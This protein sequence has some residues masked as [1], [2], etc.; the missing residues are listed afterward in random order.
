MRKTIR[1]K[2]P[3]RPSTKLA[4]LRG[5]ELTTT[6]KRRSIETSKLAK[7]LR[8]DLDWIVMKCLEKDR[9]RR[10]E[11]A[12]GLAMD[13]KRHL[14]N[15][16]VVARPPSA[17]Y[18]LQKSFR[19]NKLVFAAGAAVFVALL[20][21]MIA[22]VW[23][24]A[25]A[26][27]A[28]HEAVSARLDAEAR[29][30]EA[31][32]A[33]KA[34]T[35]QRVLA[36][37]NAAQARENE[38]HSRKLL[39]AADMN[40][41]QQSLQLNNVGR[42]RQL[43]DRHRPAPGEED[44]RGWEWRYLWQQC[45]SDALATLAKRPARGFSVSFSPDGTLL[46][47]GYLDGKIELWD[48]ARRVLLKVIETNGPGAH[49]AFSPRANL[50]AATGNGN[51]IKLHDLADGDDA[52]MWQASYES[53]RELSFS[54][55]GTRLLAFAHTVNG[56]SAVM[57]DAA[58]GQS[59]NTNATKG[60]TGHLGSARLSSDQRRLYLSHA[61]NKTRQITVKCLN[62]ETGQE[63]W[64]TKVGVD[65]GVSAMA[66]SPDDKVL[67]T[68]TGY[69]DPTIR[70][71]DAQTGKLLNKLEG[72]TG[73]VGELAF[74]RDG[75]WLASAAADQSIRLWNT[76]DWT[77]ARVFRG[78][79]NEVHAVA[80]SPDGR[81]LASG[82]KDGAIMLWDVAA[83]QSATE[84]RRLPGEA[85][86]AVEVSPGNAAT[87]N[88]E[89][90]L[91]VNLLR[92]DDISQSSIQLPA[93][94]EDG[95]RL[96][97]L[98]PNLLGVY[99][100]T[101][102]LRICEVRDQTFKTL[103]EFVVG[104]NLAVRPNIEREFGLGGV[105]LAYCQRQRLVAWGDSS[106]TVQIVNVDQPAQRIKIN[107]DL[108]DP[109]AIAFSP[110]GKLV[111]LTGG[112][113]GQGLELRDAKTGKLLLHSDLQVK[114]PHAFFVDDGRG[115]VAICAR[116][117]N[118]Q[119]DL[120]ASHQVMFWDLAHPENPPAQFPEHG[121]L[122]GLAASPDGRWVSVCSQEGFI[123]I[124]DAHTR[125][126]NKVL[127]GHMQGVHGSTFSADGR[128]F[129]SGCGGLQAVK[130]WH[131]ETGQE[132]LTLRGTGSILGDVQFM[133]RGNALMAGSPGQNGT[134]QV[135]RAPS[136]AEINAA[137]AKDKMQAQPQ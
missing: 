63:F 110:D 34:E 66:L 69:E 96:T 94:F 109:V 31:D 133:D 29:R 40:L 48:V 12:N 2:E 62:P 116:E 117:D 39:Y 53:V 57:F 49:V 77:E 13:I 56:P 80:F 101:N 113:S 14:N 37:S 65:Y 86:F 15:Q 130:L 95:S 118:G 93:W 1:E 90:K 50:L 85:Q 135:W 32:D 91:N 72:H 25:R 106:N 8:G 21:G 51:V 16:T 61:D 74:S 105:A 35:E 104:P 60:L 112:S 92:L 22:S 75:H 17:G 55:N 89:E 123:V 68:G 10:Y 26:T 38:T 73:W 20:L 30:A 108:K 23:Q 129:A 76:S 27:R 71:W 7:S 136:W 78:H 84:Y 52:V 67:A 47:A 82:G 103:A 58:T 115:F 127:Y 111:A 3:A 64:S 19:R 83:Q 128:S 44:L 36:E 98:P 97:F 79:G 132:L 99:S 126:R 81:L 88:F 46:A 124:Y 100:R 120:E 11:T 45:R 119:G 70:I 42:T 4:T 134:W 87:F 28:K 121:Y 137:E 41:A 6:A 33:R 43:L 102:R 54:A 18:R 131:V 59:M 114:L 107:S 24:A 125:E 5:D 122:A 9:T